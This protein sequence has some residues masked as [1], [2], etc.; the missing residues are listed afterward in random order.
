[1]GEEAVDTVVQ[2]VSTADMVNT[3]VDAADFSAITAGMG[4]MISEAT[5]A[6][7]IGI[8]AWVMLKVLKKAGNKIG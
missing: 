8:T 5:P 7:V 2:V 3:I 1:M 6:I 4:A